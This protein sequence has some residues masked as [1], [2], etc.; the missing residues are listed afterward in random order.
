MGVQLNQSMLGPILTGTQWYRRCGLF[1]RLVVGVVSDIGTAALLSIFDSLQPEW[2]CSVRLREPI[3]QWCVEVLFQDEPPI[4]VRPCDVGFVLWFCWWSEVRS[5][6]GHV[7]EQHGRH[8]VLPL[9]P[10]SLLLPFRAGRDHVRLREA[11][12]HHE[13]RTPRLHCIAGC[14][15]SHARLF[16]RRE[17]SMSVQ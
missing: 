10:P 12:Q 6:D 13:E 4:M 8:A 1:A 5:V 2:R 9:P 15:R 3:W 11:G 14:A 16:A 17:R 7:E